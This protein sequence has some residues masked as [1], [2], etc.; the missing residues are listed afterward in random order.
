[1]LIK[2][3]VPTPYTV[4]QH[5][6]RLTFRKRS[7]V[8]SLLLFISRAWD[9]LVLLVFP[10]D[11][12]CAF[13]IVLKS[14]QLQFSSHFN[15]INTPFL[16]KF[17]PFS[18]LPILLGKQCETSGGYWH[19]HELERAVYS[20]NLGFR[21]SIPPAINS[22]LLWITK[23]SNSSNV[24]AITAL[25]QDKYRNANFI[26]TDGAESKCCVKVDSYEIFVYNTDVSYFPWA[27]WVIRQCNT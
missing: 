1:M 2:G 16:M 10:H 19:K 11:Y 13:L 15:N 18:K 6:F 4:V 3:P 24:I 12:I 17:K 14:Y 5:S 20:P 22:P 21:K 8:S 9:V 7:M 23:S 25:Q 26:K 27:E